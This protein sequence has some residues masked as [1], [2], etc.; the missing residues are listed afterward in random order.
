VNFLFFTRLLFPIARGT[1]PSL[2]LSFS[3]SLSRLFISPRGNEDVSSA[4]RRW[5]PFNFAHSRSPDSHGMA[6]ESE[7]NCRLKRNLRFVKSYCLI[8]SARRVPKPNKSISR[9]DMRDYHIFANRK[10]WIYLFLRKRLKS[11]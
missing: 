3:F 1:P 10:E 4:S 8:R 11:F 6:R 5:L 2:S 7:E 9:I